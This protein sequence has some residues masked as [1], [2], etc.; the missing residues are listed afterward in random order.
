MPGGYRYP[1][2]EFN[3][4]GGSG[5]WWTAT[6]R[7]ESKANAYYRIMYFSQDRVYEAYDDKGYGYSVRCVK[8]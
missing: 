5:V 6:E 4:A 1:D 8:E 7:G 3:T 2:G